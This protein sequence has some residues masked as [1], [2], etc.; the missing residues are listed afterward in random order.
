MPLKY[1]QSGME[2]SH[3]FGLANKFFQKYFVLPS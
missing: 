3:D 1:V 2:A